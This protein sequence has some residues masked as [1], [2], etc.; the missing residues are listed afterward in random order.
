MRQFVV[1]FTFAIALLKATFVNAFEEKQERNNIET[2]S[3]GYFAFRQLMSDAPPSTSDGAFSNTSEDQWRSTAVLEERIKVCDHT[4]AAQLRPQLY[5]S[6]TQSEQQL[7]VDELYAETKITPTS[8]LTMGKKKV[9]GGVS[10]GYNPT[11]FL[12]KTKTQNRTLPD[13]ERR[14]EQE[15]NYQI[16]YSSYFEAYNFLLLAS[17]R[18]ENE[19]R[20]PSLMQVNGQIDEFNADF[21]LTTYYGDRPGLGFNYSTTLSGSWLGYLEYA[22]QHG[23]DRLTP[24]LS[25]EG[26]IVFCKDSYRHSQ[27]AVIGVQYTVDNGVTFNYEYWYN[28]NAYNDT[29]IQQLWHAIETKQES[30]NEANTAIAVPYLRR[31][32]LFVRI[33]EVRFLP[34]LC[35]K[36]TFEQT[37]L[38]S[39]E[40]RSRFFRSSL[41]WALSSEDSLRLAID[42][43]VGDSQ[44]EYGIN[45]VNNRILLSYKRYF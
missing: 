40:D 26:E 21:I 24:F 38:F 39:L 3:S 28:E 35:P 15:G 42:S 36:L 16:A 7:V 27:D 37:V 29:E 45:P 43:F 20:H 1:L 11:D 41:Q 13:A 8:F 17:R 33:S 44:S 18:S 6:N 4:F 30:A 14:L 34:S 19:K 25:S 31:Q 10:L 32:K 2:Q 9:V 22:I 23:R 12:N 5:Y